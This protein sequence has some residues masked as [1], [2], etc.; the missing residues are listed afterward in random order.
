MLLTVTALAVLP[1]CIADAQTETNSIPAADIA[2][3]DSSIN[4]FIPLV[5]AEYQ[6]MV[7]HGIAIRGFLAM[8]CR[9][10]VGWRNNGLPGV[11]AGVFGGTNTPQSAVTASPVK[12]A[13]GLTGR[14]GLLALFLGLALCFGVTGCGT[15]YQ[16]TEADPC[17]RIGCRFGIPIPYSGGETLLDVK[18]R[19]GVIDHGRVHQPTST[20]GP[21]NTTS[22]AINMGQ[23]DN[24][25]VGASAG[26]VSNS[27]N[28]VASVSAGDTDHFTVL[29]GQ[30][31]QTSTNEALKTGN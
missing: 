31:S 7:V 26:A 16:T 3:M 23:R 20:N 25:G 22:V 15:T 30:S 8:V 12:G 19:G 9:A 27:T 24:V 21:V 10:V 29:T 17:K 4:S 28:G 14:L 1:G 18:V 11:I 6:P 2:K 13:S 5:P